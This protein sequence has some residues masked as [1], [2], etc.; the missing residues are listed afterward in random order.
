METWDENKGFGLWIRIS[1]QK[2]S[3]VSQP[4]PLLQFTTHS[5]L[6]AKAGMRQIKNLAGGQTGMISRMTRQTRR[7][8]FKPVKRQADV[9]WFACSVSFSPPS[10]ESEWIRLKLPDA[11][12]AERPHSGMT[13]VWNNF[14]FLLS[15]MVNNG[16]LIWWKK[17]FI[18][19]LNTSALD[20]QKAQTYFCSQNVQTPR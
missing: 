12:L 10:T 14:T 17:T 9:S 5:M 11:H 6:E 8:K 16:F 2:Y 3:H 19:L 4:S 13:K 18:F 15:S 1:V 7:T 20:Q